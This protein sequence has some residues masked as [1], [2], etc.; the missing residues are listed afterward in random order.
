MKNFI[1]VLQSY[2][3]F[4]IVVFLWLVL[5]FLYIY[6]TQFEKEIIIDE[7]FTYSNKGLSQSIS[8][9]NNIV[10]VVNNSLFY[11][12]FTSTEVFNSLDI[13]NK[14]KVKGY[15]IRVPIFGMFPNII[16]ADKI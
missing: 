13:E 4:L 5:S 8:D 6:F 10:Y 15:G 12:H 1:K 3:P 2:Y 9:K 16:K 7:K 11:F 14:Y